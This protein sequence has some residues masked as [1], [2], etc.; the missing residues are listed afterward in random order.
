MYS[1]D[2]TSSN[3][4]GSEVSNKGLPL[5]LGYNAHASGGGENK[6]ID[7]A[8]NNAVVSSVKCHLSTIVT[9]CMHQFEDRLNNSMHSYVDIVSKSV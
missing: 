5:P 9:I 7:A 3:K 1:F 8:S 2:L 4:V 6:A